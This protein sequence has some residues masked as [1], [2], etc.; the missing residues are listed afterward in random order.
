MDL[1]QISP[2]WMHCCLA[3]NDHYRY[4]P[5]SKRTVAS[6]SASM[7]DV[8]VE[9][10]GAAHMVK[11]TGTAQMVETT[12]SAQMMESTGAAQGNPALKLSLQHVKNRGPLP[13]IF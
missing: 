5:E 8:D 12:G 13:P 4:C 1:D 10:T 7:S 6:G 9:A 2:L 11:A 3:Q